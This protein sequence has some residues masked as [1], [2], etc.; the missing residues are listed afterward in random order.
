MFKTVATRGDGKKVLGAIGLASTAPN[1]STGGQSEI[2]LQADRLVFVPSSDPNA[3]L[4]NLM[5][6]GLV[7]GV[8]TLRIPAAIIGDLTVGT[9]KIV[10]LAVNTGKLANNAATIT[11]S[12]VLSSSTS[13]TQGGYSDILTLVTDTGGA[14]MLLLAEI[15]YFADVDTN[16]LQLQVTINGSVVNV[17]DVNIPFNGT[18]QTGLF[19]VYVAAP[20]GGTLTV[21]IRGQSDNSP[22]TILATGGRTFAY[23]LGTKK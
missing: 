7:D 5:E 19:A 16:L 4:K 13:V 6:V 22:I 3:P 17:R 8:T 18:N 1:D 23:T 10:D 15:A 11:A 9:A 12:S 20:G 2:L 21:R 14:P